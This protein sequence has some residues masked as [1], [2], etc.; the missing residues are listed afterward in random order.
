MG[1]S[2]HDREIQLLVSDVKDG[3]LQLPELQRKYVWK[4]TQVRDF[5]DSLYRQYPTGQLLVWET[6][7]LPHARDL[8]AK[9][10]GATYRRPQLLLDG[11]QR[12]T[13]LYA[14]MTGE[15]VEVRD[16]GRKIDIVF[17]VNSEKFEVA[18]ATTRPQSGWVSLTRLFTS[19]P[20][21]I[22]DELGLSA[23]SQEGKDALKRLYRVGAIKEYKYRVTVLEGIDYDKVTDIFVRI[24]SG[25]TRLSNADLSLAQISSRWRGVSKEL[26]DFQQKAKGLGWELDD[27]ILL[28]VLSAIA[29]NQATLSQFFKAGRSEGLTEDKLREAWQRARPAMIQAIHFIKQNCLID[30]LSML[31]TNYVLVPLAVFFDRNRHVTL[32]QERDLQRW[33]YMALIWARY[34][35]SSETNLDQDIKALGEAQPVRRMIQNIE[36]KVGPGRRITERELQDELSNSPSMVLAYVLARRNGAKDWFNGVAIGEGQDLEYHHIFPKAL[37][38]QRYKDRAQSRLVNQ[39]ANLAFLSQRANSKIAASVPSEYLQQ[40]DP[41]RLQSQYVPTDTSLWT[42]DRYE[43]FVRERRQLLADAI[44]GLLAS[45]MDEPAPWLSGMSKQLEARVASAEEDLRDL[46]EHRLTANFGLLAWKRCV[47]SDIQEQVQQRI[48]QRIKRNPF[49]AGQHE[50]LAQRLA[51]CNFGDYGKIIKSNWTFFEDVFSD[52]SAFDR[53]MQA[54][55]EARNAF[56]HR[57]ELNEGE[58]QTAAGG[59]Y[60]FEQCLRRASQP[61]EDDDADSGDASTEAV[62]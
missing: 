11:Q 4:S 17:N 50:A 38:S 51:Q 61:T 26:D 54:V 44:N 36:D 31:P 41:S 23:G 49:E 9:G 27:S 1:I 28:R 45:L 21:D 30:R 53:Q 42:L 3:Y 6:D 2:A 40:V 22:L 47:P 13:S 18:T 19:D 52:K 60:W 25:G 20:V 8:S 29:S 46:I 57:R 55:Q 15:P 5:F 24:N 43:D 34:S 33:L 58:Q 48:D 7:D 35:G 62:G 14:V 39:V 59:L 10:I 56:A 16:R 32:Q 37:L 12:L